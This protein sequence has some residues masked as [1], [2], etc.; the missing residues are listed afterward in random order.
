MRGGKYRTYIIKTKQ[1]K[2]RQIK[3]FLN[4]GVKSTLADLDGLPPLQEVGVGDGQLEDQRGVHLAT[5]PLE[6][7]LEIGRKQV[8]RWWHGSVTS[9]P[10]SKI[11]I[12]GVTIHQP[13][14]QQTDI[15]VHREVALSIR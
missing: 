4:H 3:C 7:R 12:H 10:F 5:D 1:N 8:I 15:R 6:A 11:K 13:T 2:S 9:L 14:N